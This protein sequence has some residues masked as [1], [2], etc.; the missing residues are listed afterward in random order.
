MADDRLDEWTERPQVHRFLSRYWHRD[1]SV[2]SLQP[3]PFYASS[4][5]PLYVM[6]TGYHVTCG[7]P[8]CVLWGR[9]VDI[10]E[11]LRLMGAINLGLQP[12]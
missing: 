7:T 5:P 4:A 2:R 11:L 8:G 12:R 1:V 3:C 10:A 9:P 6:G